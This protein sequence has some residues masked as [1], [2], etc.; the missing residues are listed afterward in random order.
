MRLMRFLILLCVAAAWAQIPPVTQ[1]PVTLYS[2]RY[3]DIVVGTGKPAEPGKVYIVNYTGWL[4]DGAKFDSNLDKG[5]PFGFEQGKRQVIAGWD[6]GFEGMHVGGKRRLLIPYQLAY[7]LLGRPPKIPPK[8]DLTFDV[9]LLD[10]R[11]TMPQ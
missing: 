8:S 4:Q 10:V 6:S 9:E 7:G 11:D 1:K 3:I 5:K 2:M